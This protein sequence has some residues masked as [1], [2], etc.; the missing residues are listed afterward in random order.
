MFA[1][2]MAVVLTV[3]LLLTAVLSGIGW[4]TLRDQQT[5]T[6]ME[7]LRTEARE[8][9]Y[10]AAQKR[11]SLGIFD[12][13]DSSQQQY[14]QWKAT[15]IYN[16][17]GA[18]I[19]VVD[20]T[21]RMMDN[22][23][24]AYADNPD[25]AKTLDGKDIMDALRRVLAGEE[26]DLHVN[27]DG[28]DYFTVG[29]PFVQASMVL[30]AVFMQTPAQVIEAGAAGLLLPVIGV[31]AAVSLFAGLVLFLILRQVLRPLNRLTDAARAMAEGDF[32]V[33]VPQE[34]STREVEELSAAFNS[35]AD[36]LSQVED[37]RREF[38]ANVSHELR[39]P[40]TAIS[41]YIEGMRDGVIPP[42]EQDKYLSIVSD[43][44][45]RLSH[46]IGELLALSRLERDDAAIECTDFDICDLLERVFLRRTG[47]LEKHGMDID[48]DFDPEPCF[49]HADMARIDQV[50]VNL[51]DNAIKFTP[52]GGLITL[53][54]RAESGLCTVTVQDNGVGVLPEDRPRIFERF[55][56]ADRA[57]TSGKG[58]GLG[59][60]IC[61][62]ILEMHGQKIRLLD[63]V[64]GA[65]FAFTLE[66]AK[67]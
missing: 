1:R 12:R 11:N 35:M 50:L 16:K 44:S 29:V 66:T 18:Y 33:R 22:M 65:A 40:I 45:K 15:E 38:V 51:I 58:P 32:A 2:I 3:I 67:K 21:G 31:A 46:L 43:E 28:N 4:A 25:F 8:I 13:R 36:E 34:K 5:E 27:V 37:S 60:S 6:V 54:V 52:D 49:V 20:R 47:D 7:T 23:N 56:T 19:L 26:I 55:F 61:Q 9:A 63:T 53:R 10:L 17:Y 30:G 39:S 48:C 64:A 41:G 42:E 14:I 57:H 62:R 24:V 59:L